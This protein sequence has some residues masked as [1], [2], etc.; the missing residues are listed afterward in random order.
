MRILFFSI[1]LFTLSACDQHPPAP[2][3][4]TKTFAD[5]QI[6]AYDKAKDVQNVLDAADK[7]QKQDMKDE[8]L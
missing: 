8:G 3:E 6:Q 4:K 1:A 2:K 5:P 7:K